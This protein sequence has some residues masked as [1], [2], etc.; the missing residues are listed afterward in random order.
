MIKVICTNCKIPLDD[1]LVDQNDR[2]IFNCDEF[3][4]EE[5]SEIYYE[6]WDGN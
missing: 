2:V 3:C 4:S 6:G 1:C 5:C